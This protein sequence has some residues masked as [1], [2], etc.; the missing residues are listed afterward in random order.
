MMSDGGSIYFANSSMSFEATI[1]NMLHWNI[2]S[3]VIWSCQEP[4]SIKSVH[5][6]YKSLQQ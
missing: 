3:G 2:H 5:Y 1:N 6:G 4:L